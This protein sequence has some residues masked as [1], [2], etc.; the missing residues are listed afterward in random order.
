MIVAAVVVADSIV[1][2][3]VMHRSLIFLPW[4]LFGL[5]LS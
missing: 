4:G 1:L 2:N 3:S 5:V